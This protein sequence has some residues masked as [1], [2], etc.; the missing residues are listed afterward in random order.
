VLLA[1]GEGSRFGQ[2]K[3][4]VELGGQTLAERG[5][6]LLRAGGTDPILVVTGAAPIQVSGTQTVYNQEWRTG[7]GSSLRV[8]LAALAGT[9]AGAAVVALADQPLVGPQAVA[10]LIAA[11]RDGATVAVATYDGQPRNPVLLAREHWPEVAALATGDTGARAFLRARADL[12]TQVEC[13]DTG[14]A[15]DIDTPADLARIAGHST[16]SLPDR[17]ER[18]RIGGRHRADDGQGLHEEVARL[19]ELEQ[20]SIPAL[21]A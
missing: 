10:R 15:D 8:A 21:A 6:E 20:V 4:L 3:A 11:Y 12:V 18:L 7:M 14:R 13:G 16:G 19:E 17:G 1:A 9:D 2:P 5:A